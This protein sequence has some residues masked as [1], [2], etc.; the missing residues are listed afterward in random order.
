MS[1]GGIDL[2]SRFSQF[3]STY[4]LVFMAY[5]LP[6]GFL[7]ISCCSFALISLSLY[8]LKPSPRSPLSW[9]LLDGMLFWSKMSVRFVFVFVFDVYMG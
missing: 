1:V 8:Q 3:L 6:L 7:S 2:F 9:L 5:S 4:S